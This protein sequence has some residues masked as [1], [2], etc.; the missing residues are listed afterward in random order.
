MQFYQ[1]SQTSL[2]KSGSGIVEE[3][4]PI[5]LADGN[6]A[7]LNTTTTTYYLVDGGTTQ[8]NGSTSNVKTLILS[9]TWPP[10]QKFAL[11]ATIWTYASNVTGTYSLYDLTSTPTIVS[12]S[13]VTI[14]S[15]TAT[16]VRSGQFTLTPGHSYG[17][18]FYSNTSG[19]QAYICDAS[20][21]VF[22]Q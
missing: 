10:S 7:T 22:G 18:G 1:V 13:T 6:A 8:A 2:V 4:I 17:I 21:I 3:Y 19:Y 14:S 16:V 12:G 11:E 5:Y 15:T 9:S 20:L